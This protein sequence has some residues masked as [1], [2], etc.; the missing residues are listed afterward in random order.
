MT[1]PSE[2][3]APARDITRNDHCLEET[4]QAA[5]PGARQQQQEQGAAVR[6]RS[7]SRSRSRSRRPTS[8]VL[9]PLASV[10]MTGSGRGLGH[11]QNGFKP[12]DISVFW[13]THF[14]QTHPPPG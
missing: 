9:V 5:G 1:G 3:I 4:S 7:R 8:L 14:C 10:V 6:A 2:V 11:Y 12:C 13:R